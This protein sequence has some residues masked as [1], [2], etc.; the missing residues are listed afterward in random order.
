MD[1]IVD[2]PESNGYIQIWVIVDKFT[3]IVYLNPL[4][5]KVSAKDIADL[6]VKAIWKTHGLLTDIMSDRNT[7]I[8]SHFW[9]V[10]MDLLGVKTKLSTAFHSDTDGQT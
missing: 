10:L 9:Q 1:W 8:T 2:L 4:P 3:K 6:I 5:I 7:K